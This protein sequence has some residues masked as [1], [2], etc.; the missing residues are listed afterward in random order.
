[1]SRF[2]Q[3]L[4]YALRQL[5]QSPRFTAV[6]LISLA[7]GIGAN[8]AIFSLL[9]AVLLKTLPVR[10]PERLVLM[11]QG[12]DQ[13]SQ[14]YPIWEAFRDRQQ[15]LD[16]AL[17]WGNRLFNLGTP[18]AP[19]RV[20]GLFVSGSAFPVLGVQPEAGS[21]FTS[22][23]D[24]PG[25]ELRA[26]LGYGY[27][28]D[29][30]GGSNDAIGKSLIIDGKPFTIMGVAQNGFF[31]MEVGNRFSV[32]IPFCAEPELYGE[33][34]NLNQRSSWW[35]TVMGR[36]KPGQTI[37][38]A[39][40]GVLAIQT[41]IRE[42][43]LPTDWRPEDLKDYLKEPF[44]FRPAGTGVSYLRRQYETALYVLMGLVGLVLL[45]A[46]ANIATLLLARGS[47]RQRE[48]A[49]RLALGAS[50]S[51][52]VRQ[53]LTET[54]LLAVLG[55]ALGI[56][57]SYWGTQLLAI[58][59]STERRIIRLDLSPDLR[60]ILFTSGL[61]VM[62]AI[63]SGLAPALRAT[64]LA[65]NQ[66][67]KERATTT[68]GE[69]RFGLGRLL[70]VAQI[71][72]SMLM[73][74]GAG[75]L[76]RSFTHLVTQDSGFNSQNVLVAEFN[77][78][79]SG[80][81]PPEVRQGVRD[82]LRDLFAAIP[83]VTSAALA[84]VTPISGSSWTSRI[85][86]EGFVPKSPRDSGVY[87]NCVSPEYF[88]TMSIA[89][90]AGRNFGPADK[91]GSPRVAIVNETLARKFF[92]IRNPVGMTY[93][94]KTLK[95][96]E[97]TEIIGVVRDSKYRNLMEPAP[98]T[99]YVPDAQD[100]DPDRWGAVV[101]KANSDLRGVQAAA[102][103]EAEGIHKELSLTFRMFERQIADSLARERTLAM[104]SGFFA[105]LALLLA[106]I[107]L[108]GLTSYGV[109]RRRNEIGIRMALGALPASVLRMI[110]REVGGLAAVG[111]VI[112]IGAAYAMSKW[113]ATLIF[114]IEH[115]DPTTFAGAVAVLG[116]VALLAGYFPAR[117]A[118]RL[119]PMEALRDE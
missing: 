66:A 57:V 22:E 89:L 37:E 61:A 51:G 85:D 110:L 12:K 9:N 63:L 73:V 13:V 100:K 44:S 112:G 5:R 75:L 78:G 70:V 101:I 106:A 103:R 113:L 14:T 67:L 108:Y 39:N 17:T 118:A 91:V 76:L 32:A 49:V 29:H 107:G 38:Q 34:S 8:T 81:L 11:S 3:D 95:G 80:P 82:Q 56:I 94:Q 90:L 28:M 99:V 72:L 7:L 71:A 6:V 27:W 69:R 74:F 25:C 2:L 46:C 83:G 21:L 53:L 60:V 92:A 79:G 58:Y 115:R 116:I 36:L 41:S 45:V 59:L 20:P 114:G 97:T 52:L 50:R 33:Q 18:L 35:L 109:G 54:T 98:P 15:F 96:A 10:E 43:T 104:L 31:G 84:N 93:S 48:F 19:Q 119:H 105:A 117:R 64:Q 86:V 30:Y 4:S 26:V 1:M 88:A 111:I 77:L 55:A 40:A 42:A 68:G 23:D 47:G 65:P 24:R 87:M 16:G 62:T 102:I